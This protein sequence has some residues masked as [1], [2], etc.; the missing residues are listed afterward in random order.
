MKKEDLIF[1][2]HILEAIEKINKYL[3]KLD[4]K[5]F[6][7]NDVIQDAISRRLEIIGEATKLLSKDL[8]NK[9]S[10]IPWKDIAGMRDKLIHGYF[11]VDLDEVWS[12][13]MRDIPK[14]RKNIKKIISQIKIKENKD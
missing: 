13:S 7:E 6:M 11:I 1:L 14:L 9:F 10:E 12:T 4:Y 2:E 3:E 5:K 8:R